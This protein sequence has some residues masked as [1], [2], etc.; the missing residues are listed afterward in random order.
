M[1]QNIQSVLSTFPGFLA[2]NQLPS[3]LVSPIVIPA[4]NNQDVNTSLC[5][6][7]A[8]RIYINSVFGKALRDCL[9]RIRILMRKKSQLIPFLGEVYRQLNWHIVKIMWISFL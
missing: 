2:K 1:L 9:F 6:F 7:R 8:L 4:L 5:P 3:V